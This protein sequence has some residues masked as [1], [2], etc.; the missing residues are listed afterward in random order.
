MDRAG[1]QVGLETDP[2]VRRSHTSV[3]NSHPAHVAAEDVRAL[4]GTIQVTGWSGTL[5]G[6]LETP[7][8]I[9]VF[10]DQELDSLAAPVSQ[11]LAQASPVER[12]RFSLA[13]TRKG[14]SDDRIAGALFLRGRYLH[15]LLTDHV[16]FARAD[17]GGADEKDP[18]DT[19]GMK[20]WVSRPAV[21]AMVPDAEE[22]AWAPFE[23]VHV[24]LIVTETLAARRSPSAKRA[25]RPPTGYTTEGSAPSAATSTETRSSTVE[26]ADDSRLQIRELTHSNLELRGRLEEQQRTIEELRGELK[27]LRQELEATT[28]RSKKP[29]KP[30]P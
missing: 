12:V 9:A 7:P 11:A 20:L 30:T 4:L 5:V 28:F 14:I 15:F 23:T 8:A 29:A 10:T 16:A 26:Q 1:V 21:A 19:K 27:R 22:P 24:P 13:N 3:Q 18:R 2:S 25:A 6:M 17:T